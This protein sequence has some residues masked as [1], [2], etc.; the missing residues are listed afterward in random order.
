MPKLNHPKWFDAQVNHK[1]PMQSKHRR[2][3]ESA[4]NEGNEGNETITL[5]FTLPAS[6]PRSPPPLHIFSSRFGCSSAYVRKTSCFF[7]FFASDAER[8]ELWLN[9]FMRKIRANRTAHGTTHIGNIELRRFTMGCF[10]LLWI[11]ALYS[12]GWNSSSIDY[13]VGGAIQC[14]AL[15]STQ[16]KHLE[17]L[18]F[19]AK[20]KLK[21]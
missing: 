15:H 12:S 10:N 3:W 18:I 8:L 17:H 2:E 5:T 9:A 1:I 6:P 4:P 7:F 13:D 21:P 20:R 16:T 14:A 19:S 11:H